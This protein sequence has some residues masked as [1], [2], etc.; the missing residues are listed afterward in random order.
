MKDYWRQFSQVWTLLSLLIAAVYLVVVVKG[1]ISESQQITS[2]GVQLHRISGTENKERRGDVIF[3]H[4][5]DGHFQ[6]TWETSRPPGSK[7]PSL[8]YFPKELGDH[9][10][11][12][13]IWSV[14]YAASSSEWY[15]AWMPIEDRS[16]NLLE[17]LRLNG[18]GDKPIIFV[19]HSL[20]GLMAKQM[21]VD[22]VDMKWEN[23]ENI[24]ANVRGVSFLATPHN[25]SSIANY[26]DLLEQFFKGGKVYRTTG[27][28][29]Q[30]RRNASMLRRLGNNYKRTAQVFEIQTQAFFESENTGGAVRVVDEDSADPGMTNV[31]TIGVDADHNSICK[32]DS[33]GHFVYL[34]VAD[35]VK[36]YLEPSAK[37]ID[38][39]MNKFL[40]EFH[41]AKKES[42]ATLQAFIARHARKSLVTWDV[43]VQEPYS[44]EGDNDPCL[45]VRLAVDAPDS[46]MAYFRPSK[47]PAVTKGAR[48]KI[49]GVVSPDTS[50][51]GVHLERCERIE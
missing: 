24:A 14:E 21:F 25:G 4:G 36:K 26:L 29:E 35:F 23:W 48:I 39:P 12:V 51:L 46:V 11:D 28:V 8:F 44:A 38:T 6:T 15:G 17:L 2:G 3:I 34:Q 9:Y 18:V 37:P 31:L 49:S 1:C 10:K 43:V 13:G 40:E 30:L 22:A 20:G 45:D 27:Q 33:R 7:D 32:P 19:T 5:L 50:R 42:D 41:A 16:F 47:Y